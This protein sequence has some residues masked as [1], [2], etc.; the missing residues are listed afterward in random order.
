MTDT[1]RERVMALA[2]ADE[3]RHALQASGHATLV[4]HGL[5]KV[6]AGITTLQEVA[7][8]ARGL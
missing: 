3:M 7:A 6:R 2:S 1:L 8:V 5:E 4:A